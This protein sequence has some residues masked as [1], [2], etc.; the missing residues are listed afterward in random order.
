MNDAM[1]FAQY[2]GSQYGVLG[3]IAL[4]FFAFVG[5]KLYSES[6]KGEPKDAGAAVNHVV[7][8]VEDVKKRLV[9]V[10]IDLARLDER[11]KR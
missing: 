4:L 8:E 5:W 9:N 3:M 1:G 11:T 2:I 7:R 6:N 10:E